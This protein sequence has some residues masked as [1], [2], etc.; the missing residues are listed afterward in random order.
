MPAYPLPLFP[1]TAP[2]E[3]PLSGFTES[4]NSGNGCPLPS[5][6]FS[7]PLV[8]PVV[9]LVLPNYVYP[10]VNDGN[11][12]T[13]CPAQT[14]FSFQPAFSSQALF[15]TQPPFTASDIFPPQTLYPTQP[16]PY[17]PSADGENNPVIE[18][19]YELACSC[20]PQSPDPEDQASPSLFQSRCSSPLNLLQLEE[21]PKISDCG[22][23]GTLGNHGAVA[24]GGATSKP[25][26]VDGFSRKVLSPV[27]ISCN[28]LE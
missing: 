22:A 26:S 4:Q 11:P 10:Q 25:R 6:Q 12:E 20:T 21:M 19:Q 3:A 15:T 28:C 14:S 18:T 2:T 8:T 5:S 16:F 27:S 24:D 13:L 7:A 23:A 17:K 1:Q 9:A